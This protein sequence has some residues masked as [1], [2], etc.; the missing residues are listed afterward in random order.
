MAWVRAAGGGVRRA[1]AHY[2]R[3]LHDRPV[4][5]NSVTAAVMA[6]TGDVTAQA[7]ERSL[8]RRRGVAAETTVVA[9]TRASSAPVA[10]RW[11]PR[12]SMSV[13]LWGLTVGGPPMVWWF[14]YL[15]R[16][17]GTPVT[18]PKVYPVR[19][20]AAAAAAAAASSVML[21]V[22]AVHSRHPADAG[23]RITTSGGI[24][25]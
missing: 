2:Q 6:F 22:F 16:L 12:R 18:L 15:S 23:T 3:L 8:Q 4:V 14:G 13:F 9:A 17:G 11:Q 21:C 1:W 19:Q 25:S 10:G 5:T 24:A 20:Q 7:I